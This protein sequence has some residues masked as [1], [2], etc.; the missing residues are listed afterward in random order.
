MKKIHL[1]I[2][3]KKYFLLG[4]MSSFFIVLSVYL[5]VLFHLASRVSDASIKSSDVVLVL[6]AA[7]YK[8]GRINPCLV[9]RVE[10]G[11]ELYNNDVADVIL[12]S[13]GNDTSP[14]FANEAE[15]MEKIARDRY[16]LPEALLLETKATSTYE[17]LYYSKA[18][19][20][21]KGFDSVIIVTEGF[22]MPR[23]VDTAQKVFGSSISFGFAPVMKTECWEEGQ[24]LNPHM[25]REPFAY[26]SYL[27]TGKL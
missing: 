5:F 4:V 24:V 21:E 11:I 20:E 18:L 7:S 13:G 25:L 10:K 14:P 16:I 2:P 22:H 19:L 1:G 17:N 3:S 15:T 9:S 6:G 12:L 8:N 23:A 26:L 27:L